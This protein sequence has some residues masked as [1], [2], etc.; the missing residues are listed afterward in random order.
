[1]FFVGGGIGFG[2][3]LSLKVSPTITPV[4]MKTTDKPHKGARLVAMVRN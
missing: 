2:I 1:V 3:M 4:I